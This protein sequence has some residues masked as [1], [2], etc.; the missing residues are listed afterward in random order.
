MRGMEKERGFTLIE[1]M[2][3]LVVLGILGAIAVPTFRQFT[4]NTRVS[5]AT[6]GLAS[7]LARARSEALLRGVPVSVCSGD[8]T[9]CSAGWTQGWIVFIDT[10][11]AGQVDPPDDT[12]LQAWPSPGATISIDAGPSNYIQYDPRGMNPGG[13]VTFK[14]WDAS[15]CHGARRSQTIVTVTGSPQMS[16]IACP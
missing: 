9:G 2:L 14:I 15:T 1:A 16:Y 6:N 12:I 4:S 11:I 8:Q 7:A 13:A 10:A 5:A 3:A